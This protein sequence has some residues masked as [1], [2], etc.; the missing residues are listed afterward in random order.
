MAKKKRRSRSASPS[1]YGTQRTQ[2]NNAPSPTPQRDESA[3]D[4]SKAVTSPTRQPA[5][6]VD[7]AV[8]Y[9]YVFQDLR[10]I[11]IL[12]GAILSVLVILSFVVP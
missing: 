2:P 5:G 9:R 6:K 12:A 1:R 11:A 4:V 3:E 10:R 8:E 7:F